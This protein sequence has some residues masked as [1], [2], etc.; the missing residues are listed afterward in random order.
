MVNNVILVGRVVDE[1][2]FTTLNDS[3]YRVANFCM[4]VRKD[5]RD[6]NNNYD[7]DFVP[8]VAWH[9]TAEVV[10]DYVH[11]G[12]VIGV[13]GRVNMRQT[14]VNGQKQNLINLVVEN[15]SFISMTDRKKDLSL[16]DVDEAN[17][18]ADDTSN[19]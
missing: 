14:D 19:N 17:D 6:E 8:L 4:A 15:V 12:S 18:L 7:S 1:P 11:K 13:R 3:G 16:E 9:G 10:R 2:R 5:F